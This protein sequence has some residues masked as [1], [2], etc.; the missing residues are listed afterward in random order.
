MLG[1]IFCYLVDAMFDKIKFNLIDLRDFEIKEPKL[2]IKEMFSL[3][4]LL[5]KPFYLSP[6][7][8]SGA[9]LRIHFN[10]PSTKHRNE[11]K[12]MKLVVQ[13]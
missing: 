10:F 7:N 11:K 4:Y 5:L 1:G 12:N 6:F 9:Q 3:F 2:K 8:T 13:L